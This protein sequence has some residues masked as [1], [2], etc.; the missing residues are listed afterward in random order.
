MKKSASGADRKA[1]SLKERFNYW[2]DNRM[3]R[4][5]L[6]LIRSL[7]A[8]SILLAVVVAA[9]IV[10]FIRYLPALAD[11]NGL[12]MGLLELPSTKV[13]LIILAVG[14]VLTVPLVPIRSLIIAA[15]AGGDGS[16]RAEEE[17]R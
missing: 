2:F 9:L 5:S 11:L 8:A 12:V 14:V 1:F 7:V 3:A 4:G 6:G 10:L 16:R 13:S 15:C 17:D